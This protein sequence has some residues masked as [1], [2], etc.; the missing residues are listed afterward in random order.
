MRRGSRFSSRA[1][2]RDIGSRAAACDAF[3]WPPSGALAPTVGRRRQYWMT[4]ARTLM[5]EMWQAIPACLL[6]SSPAGERGRHQN[7]AGMEAAARRAGRAK[8]ALQVPISVPRELE[9]QAVPGAG[10]AAIKKEKPRQINVL[11][12]HIWSWLDDSNPRPADY[13]SAALPTELRQRSGR[14]VRTGVPA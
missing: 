8:P 7:P 14:H 4:L 13:K 3:A 10:T 12:G 5:A 11:R 1:E 6:R 9:R 2:S